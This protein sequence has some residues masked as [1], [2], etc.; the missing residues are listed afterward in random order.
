MSNKLQ[1]YSTS[2]FIK[3]FLS[4]IT[5]VPLPFHEFPSTFLENFLK[6]LIHSPCPCL[7]SLFKYYFGNHTLLVF[8]I[9]TSQVPLGKSWSFL[10][11]IPFYVFKHIL[12]PGLPDLL[13]FC[14]NGSLGWRALSLTP[15]LPYTFCVYCRLTQ[16]QISTSKHL[17]SLSSILVSIKNII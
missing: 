17:W 13:T 12:F 11:W 3:L 4:S 8:C 6:C 5:I 9:K 15:L 1:N 2:F 10:M 7:Q 14:Y 16:L